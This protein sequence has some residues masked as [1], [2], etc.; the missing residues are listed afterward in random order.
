MH[1][2]EESNTMVVIGIVPLGLKNKEGEKIHIG[3]DRFQALDNIPSIK[4]E[5][6]PG[7]YK[8]IAL[9]GRTAG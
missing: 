2:M 4:L 5:G 7:N 3:P 1:V 8:F 9:E 6:L